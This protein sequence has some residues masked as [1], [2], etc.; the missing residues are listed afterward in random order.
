MTEQR[1][2]I[3]QTGSTQ[4]LDAIH[5]ALADEPAIT[6][7]VEESGRHYSVP[8]GDDLP[9]WTALRVYC[10]TDGD[11]AAFMDALR[12]RLAERLGWQVVNEV[13]FASF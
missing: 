9:E 13:T 11:V 7:I 2:T 10:Q 12:H 5:R 6:A 8:D 4:E 1:F 3:H